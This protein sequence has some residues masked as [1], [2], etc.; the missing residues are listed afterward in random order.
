MQTPEY[1]RDSRT[2]RNHE[3][4][5]GNATPIKLSFAMVIEIRTPDAT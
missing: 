1:K 5:I 4:I 2:D 3:W